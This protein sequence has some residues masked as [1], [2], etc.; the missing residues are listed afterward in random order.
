M[1]VEM[2]GGPWDGDRGAYPGSTRVVTAHERHHAS[3]S[4]GYMP[5]PPPTGEYRI[6]DVV[7]Y[8]FISAEVLARPDRPRLWELLEVQVPPTPFYWHLAP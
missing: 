5:D 3:V 6:G 1:L 8:C 2:I 4:D 7:F